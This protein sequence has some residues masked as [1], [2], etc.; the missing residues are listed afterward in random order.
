VSSSSGQTSTTLPPIPFESGATPELQVQ[1]SRAHLLEAL[2]HLRDA[3]VTPTNLLLLILDSDVSDNALHILKGQL[4]RDDYR[5][6]SKIL[7]ALWEDPKGKS[8]IES[9][10]IEKEVALRV[11]QDDEFE[12]VRRT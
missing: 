9:W 5:N 12:D 7:D 11:V 4:V 8:H 3:R 2:Q 6:V 1:D 10:L